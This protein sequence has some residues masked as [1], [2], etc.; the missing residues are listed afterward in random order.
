MN[1]QTDFWDETNPLEESRT[2]GC[3]YPAVVVGI[4]GLA[5]IALVTWGVTVLV[6]SIIA[7]FSSNPVM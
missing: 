3:L 5:I 2:E 7:F 1:E 4:A 6:M